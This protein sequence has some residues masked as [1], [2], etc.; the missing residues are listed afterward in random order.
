MTTVVSDPTAPH[1]AS[2]VGRVTYPVGFPGG[3]GVG[4][5]YRTV[6]AYKTLY[7][8]TWL[9]F[10]SNW[11][12]NPTGNNKMLYLF[13]DNQQMMITEATGSGSDP[14]KHT[15]YLEYLG[16]PYSWYPNAFGTPLR[17]PIPHARGQP[18]QRRDQAWRMAS[19]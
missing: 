13:M 3:Q 10:S 18:D 4:E 7:I 6:G 17:R 12:G 14:L 16:A 9:K 11:V 2:N 19:L 15:I 8:S 5:I 1:S